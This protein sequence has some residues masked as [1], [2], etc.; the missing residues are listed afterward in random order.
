MIDG[1]EPQSATKGSG[2]PWLGEAP[3]PVETSGEQ[4]SWH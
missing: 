1:I 4:A 3:N 2:A